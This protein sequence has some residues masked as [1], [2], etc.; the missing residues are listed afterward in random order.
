MERQY[1]FFNSAK[2]FWFSVIAFALLWVVIA[3]LAFVCKAAVWFVSMFIVLYCA[4]FVYLAFRIDR[5]NSG[6]WP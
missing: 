6:K 4:C 5:K 2:A 1:I 3:C